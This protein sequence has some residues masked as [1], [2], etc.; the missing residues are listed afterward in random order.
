MRSEIRKI[1]VSKD[2]ADN[3]KLRETSSKQPRN[4]LPSRASCHGFITWR[5]VSGFFITLMTDQERKDRNKAYARKYAAANR[6]KIAEK[7]RK[8]RTE[9]P[10]KLKATKDKWRT[11]NPEKVAEQRRKWD[12]ANPDKIAEQKRKYRESNRQKIA[13]ET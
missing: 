2:S 1:A 4:L 11:F 3:G 8:Y 13:A 10:E 12:A 6:E 7:G 5:G 9:N